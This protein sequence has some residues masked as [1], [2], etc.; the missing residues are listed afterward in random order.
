VA[1]AGTHAKNINAV[2]IAARVTH[3]EILCRIISAP[4]FGLG[5]SS[6]LNLAFDGGQVI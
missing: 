3:C 6:Y 2:V 5:R 4:E 1:W